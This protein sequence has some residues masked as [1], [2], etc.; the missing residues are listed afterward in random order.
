L[1]DN[2]SQD[3]D[4]LCEL[5][6][7]A[8]ESG[9]AVGFLPPFAK[10]QAESYWENLNA[11]L[12]TSRLL[13]A[14]YSGNRLVG[15][16]QLDLAQMPSARHRAEVQN[17]F[18]FRNRRGEGIGKLLMKAVEVKAREID[19]RL[20]IADA[21]MGDVAEHLLQR[22]DYNRVGIIPEYTKSADGSL[23]ATVIFCKYLAGQVN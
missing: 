14:A 8:V 15:C 20:L 19:R 21:R 22:L 10:W 4:T 12:S 1:L 11:Q 2:I 23:H 7:D 3:K 5:L 9:A 17:I 13:F 16:V 18:V 6:I